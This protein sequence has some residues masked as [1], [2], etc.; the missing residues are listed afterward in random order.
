MFG[1]GLWFPTLLLLVTPSCS[2]HPCPELNEVTTWIYAVV[3]NTYLVRP[4]MG[5]YVADLA[6][7]Y[8]TA[9]PP[10]SEPSEPELGIESGDWAEGAGEEGAESESSV[11]ESVC[12]DSRGDEDCWS[13]EREPASKRQRR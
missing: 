10:Q 4:G 6:L 13:S 5:L 8:E 3:I 2:Y 11:D 1:Q 12:E 7:W 9:E